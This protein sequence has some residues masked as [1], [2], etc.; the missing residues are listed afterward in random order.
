MESGVA[1]V[2]PIDQLSLKDRLSRLSFTDACKLLVPQGRQLIQ[3]NANAW[4]ISIQ[5]DVYMGGDLLRVRFPA[6]PGSRPPIVTITLKSDAR[7]RLHYRCDRCDMACEHVGAAFS[8]ILEEKTALG[9]AEPPPEREPVESLTEEDLVEQALAD[10]AERARTEKM[11]VKSSEPE[12]PWTDYS[13]TNLLSG[14]TYRVSLRGLK[15]GDSFCSCPDYRT[16]TLGICKHIMRAASIVKKKF[17]VERLRQRFRPSQITV[18]LHYSSEVS[19]RLLVP[20]RLDEDSAE[21]IAPLRDKA[22]DNLPDLLKRIARLQKAGREVFIYPDAEE[23]IQQRMAQKRLLAAMEEIRRD[24]EQHP[25]R[26]S[27][28]KTHLL[29][30]QM[31]GIAFALGAGRAILAD[32]MGLGKTIQGVGTAELLAREI[33]IR[34]VLV[35]CPASLKS[36]WR[37]EIHKFCDRDVQLIAGAIAE[38]S[39]QYSND[40]FFTVCNYEQV[41]RD[42]QSIDRAAWDLIILD[43]G[44]RIKNWESKTS[45]IVKCLRSRFALVLTGTPLENRLDDLFSVVQFVDDRRLGPGFRFFNRHRIVDEKGK[46]LGYKNL[47][48]LRETLKPILLRRTRDSVKLELP[49][50][51]VEIVRITPTAE[52]LTAHASHMQIVASITRKKFITEMDLLRLQKALLMCRMLANSTFL[53]DK[54]APG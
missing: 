1:T 49:P 18:H 3:S 39:A 9:L 36:Q 51:S 47:G 53:A 50:R 54:K 43:E 31:D 41:I 13:V 26:T 29:P 14:R 28:L 4:S 37:N 27:L 5:D 34:K 42:L 23:F 10:R 32:E 38:R 8:L 12:S 20:D 24:P 19:L 17:P 21:T 45:R 7:Q 16:N 40:C 48:E 44:Q 35:I 30:Y 15:P 6:E 25:L 11:K 46:V 2:L 22:I 33:G 52:Q